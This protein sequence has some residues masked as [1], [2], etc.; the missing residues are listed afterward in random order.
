MQQLPS[1]QHTLSETIASDCDPRI[2]CIPLD[3]KPNSPSLK[4]DADREEANCAKKLIHL[5][6]SV[7]SPVSPSYVTLS[8]YRCTFLSPP[9]THTLCF[10]PGGPSAEYE[11]P[12][13]RG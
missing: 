6:E 9:C 13:S 7:I 4:I 8:F 5:S 1:Y 12:P 2:I 3:G 11:S 10:N